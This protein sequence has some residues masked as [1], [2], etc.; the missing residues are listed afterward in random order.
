MVMDIN[1]VSHIP[2]LLGRPFLATVSAIIYVKRG[3]LSLEV[4]DENIRF[5]LSQF[6]KNPSMTDSYYFVDIIDERVKD[7]SSEPP[8]TE[9]LDAPLTK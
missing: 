8:S 5:I 3:K 9:E 1:E 2:I 7:L 6:L 4:E